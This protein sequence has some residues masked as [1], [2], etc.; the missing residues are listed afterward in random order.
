LATGT[1]SRSVSVSQ[2]TVS[3][4]L[5][6]GKREFK[7]FGYATAPQRRTGKGN[8]RETVVTKTSELATG[9]TQYGGWLRWELERQELNA[10]ELAQRSGVHV[11][12]ILALL[13]GKLRDRNSALDTELKR[14]FKQEVRRS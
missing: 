5:R 11:N 12:T 10:V 9:E 2:A 6:T 13:E 1:H 7:V 4:W 3:N 14:P 8:G